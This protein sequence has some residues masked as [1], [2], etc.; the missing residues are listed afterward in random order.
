MFFQILFPFFLNTLKS[1]KDRH[2]TFYVEKSF[3]HDIYIDNHINF[4]YKS[5]S[6][7]KLAWLSFA[8]KMEL[9]EF[10]EVFGCRKGNHA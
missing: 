2:S 5:F 9:L 6:L 8:A 3:F 10:K 1:G 7:H 4:L